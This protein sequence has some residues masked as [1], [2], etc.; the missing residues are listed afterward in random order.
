[1]SYSE[2]STIH[3]RWINPYAAKLGCFPQYILTPS[4]FSKQN[5]HPA[6]KLNAEA[7]SGLQA[8]ILTKIWNFKAIN[9][10]LGAGSGGHLISRAMSRR[11]EFFIG[12]E[13]RYKRLVRC[14]EKAAHEN[15]QNI[16]FIQCLAE[17]ALDLF[18]DGSLNSVFVLFPD[19][20]GKR[21]WKKNRLINQT[22]LECLAVKLSLGGRFILKTDHQAYFEDVV[23]AINTTNALRSSQFVNYNDWSALGN[24]REFASEF[25]KLFLSKKQ[26]IYRLE[27]EK[28]DPKL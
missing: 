23:N 3:K 11:N 8:L 17:Q 19:P 26:M 2:V 24:D 4:V 13:L 15:L 21:R 5:T 6:K 9:L 28:P 20:W 18:P 1:M 10:E 14:A 25:E 27:A 22:L 16:L 7:I 12:V